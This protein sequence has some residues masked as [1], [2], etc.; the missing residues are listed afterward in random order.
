MGNVLA[1]LF[2]SLLR[3]LPPTTVTPFC[4]DLTS[5]LYVDVSMYANKKGIEND[6][7][8]YSKTMSHCQ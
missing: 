8:T 2:N 3:P 6:D 1:N 7:D 4:I 5:V